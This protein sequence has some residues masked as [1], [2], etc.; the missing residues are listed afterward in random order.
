[1]NVNLFK[2]LR[3][4]SPKLVT[5]DEVV[6]FIREDGFVK[7]RTERH[8]YYLSQG[9]NKAA[10]AEKLSCPCFSVATLFCGGK[11]MKDVCGWTGLGMVDVDDVDAGALPALSERVAADG[12]TLLVYRTISGC[13][14]R[15][16]FRYESDVAEQLDD[17]QRKLLY[18]AA[19]EMANGYYQSLLQVSPDPKC[20]THT[21]VSGMA[22]DPE[23]CYR[24][25]AEPFVI[26]W[27]ACI[28]QTKHQESQRKLLRSAVKAAH[29][30]ITAQG[31]EF[32]PGSHNEY[33]MRMGY[34]LNVYGVDE[35]VAA[36]WAVK[37]FSADYHDNIDGIIRS[38]YKHTE[39]HGKR[40]M[41]KKG[42]S[43]SNEKR[44]ASV[45]EIERFLD[46]QVKLRFNVIRRQCEVKWLDTPSASLVPLAEGQYGTSSEP[47]DSGRTMVR[48]YDLVDDGFS[49]ITDR[50]ENTL[51][52]RMMKAQGSV[53]LQDIRNVLQSEY[54]P[55][56]NPFEDYFYSLPPWDGEDHIGQLART[57]HVKGSQE[58]FVEYFRKWLVGMLPTIFDPNV[59]NHEIMV[60]IGRQGNFKS[61]F[62]SLL[63]PPCLQ[64]YFHIKMNS[65]NL[66]KDDMLKMC[67]FAL[68]CLEEIG[69][70]QQL[71]LDQQK[72]L[73]T[74][75]IISERAAYARNK[76]HRPHIASFCGTGNNPRFLTDITGNRR[77]LVFEV[78]DIDNPLQHPFNY[79]GIY[80]QAMA[81]WKSGFCYWFEQQEINALNIRNVEFEV[82]NLE[83]ELVLTYF[84]QPFE[85]CKASFM[86]VAEVLERINAGIRHPLSPTKLGIIMTQLG[87]PAVKR[88]GRRGYLVIERSTDEIQSSRRLEGYFDN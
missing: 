70:M 29:Q 63:L 75:K 82:P 55:M 84:R 18:E 73:V 23:A 66:T 38:C 26:D 69:E 9:M 20:K 28:G 12:H 1:M 54:V 34:L 11:T 37:Q 7:D 72:A 42:A 48:P 19:F 33:V 8:R 71:A 10:S 78:E 17:K 74:D 4:R 81:L 52:C 31:V 6:R 30:E 64:S 57:V 27:S 68:I 47:Q 49:P 16:L 44:C 53:R 88:N 25:E 56:F 14:L 36:D 43:L 39:E 61:T 41:T 76:E 67:E 58:Q 60:F 32:R 35:E 79:T 21:Q 2:D 86:K 45:E 85:G 80:S 51:W 87:F 15:I 65:N 22:H 77:W 50:D 3:D 83:E 5:L 40:R 59:V 13:G 46:T 24:P 62:F